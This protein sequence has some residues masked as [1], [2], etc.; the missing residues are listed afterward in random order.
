MN[1]A[2]STIAVVEHFYARDRA[3]I[4]FGWGRAHT[5]RI[6]FVP[7]MQAGPALPMQQNDPAVSAPVPITDNR[8]TVGNAFQNTLPTA[9]HC[10]LP[11]V[12]ALGY[13]AGSICNVALNHG[14]HMPRISGINDKEAKRQARKLRNRES[15][16]RS[17]RKKQL[18]NRELKGQLALE[19]GKLAKL[20]ARLETIREENQALRSKLSE[21]GQ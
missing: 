9:F 14:V 1:R 15:A 16:A 4:R 11:R 20:R 18:Q 3:K 7:E 21:N 19:K 2:Y 17:N 12:G 10:I 8:T 13:S 6:S 5:A